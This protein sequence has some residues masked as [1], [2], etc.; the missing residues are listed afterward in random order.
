LELQALE[1]KRPSARMTWGVF[2]FLKDIL[3]ENP[4]KNSEKL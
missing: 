1:V 2:F 4:T 3:R